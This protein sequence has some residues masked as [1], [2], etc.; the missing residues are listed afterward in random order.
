MEGAVAEVVAM[1]VHAVG[2]WI[3]VRVP[4]S[5]RRII[6]AVS[7]DI[8]KLVPR[9]PEFV[10]GAEAQGAAHASLTRFLP[11]ADEVSCRVSDSP[12]FIDQGENF[13]RVRCPMC[14]AELE[15]WWTGAMEAAY[16]GRGFPSLAITVPCCGSKSSLNELTYDWP[17]GFARFEL[18]ALNP[19]A[20]LKKE[21]MAEIEQ[22]LGCPLL[23]VRCRY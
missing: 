21:Q 3:R 2:E 23:V 19:G 9:D 17:A 16:D 22:L 7:D 4:A 15:D 10:P 6:G 12:Q 1:A 5:K 13:E 8:V 18:R 20:E 11:L 14:G